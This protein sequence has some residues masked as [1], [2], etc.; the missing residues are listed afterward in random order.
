MADQRAPDWVIPMMRAGYSARGLVY[1]ILGGLTMSAALWGGN[2]EGTEGAL[3][4]LRDAPFGQVLLWLVAF[5]FICYGIWRFIAAY[6]DLENRGDEEKGVLQRLALVVTGLIH[7]GLGVGMATVAMGVGGSSGGDGASDWTAKVLQ[8]PGGKWIV[9]IAA[10]GILGAG[11]HYVIKGWKKKYKRYIQNNEKT[12]K[13]E[14]LLRWGFVSYGIVLAIVGVFL[15]FAAINSDPSSAMG[16]GGALD[17]IRGLTGGR[18]LLGVIA[19]G[20]IGF[21]VE[22]FVEARYRIVPGV[23]DSSDIQSMAQAAKAKAESKAR[24]ATAG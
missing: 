10:L 9:G 3:Q 22:N 13:L 2:T 5:G 24:A 8:M 17:Y 14:P 7:V 20:I 18:I 11:I 15:G 19:L 6:F 1:L 4:T 16:L 23:D 12:Q 21:G